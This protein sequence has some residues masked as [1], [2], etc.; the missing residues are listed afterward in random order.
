MIDG[1]SLAVLGLLSLLWG[2]NTQEWEPLPAIAWEQAKVF[3]VPTQ[4]DPVVTEIFQDYLNILAAKGYDPNRQGIWIQSEW[5][6]LVQNQETVPVSAASL[7]KIATSLAALDKWDINHRFETRLYALGAVT[8]GVLQGDLLIEGGGDPLFVWEEAIAVGNAL[9]QLGIREVTGNLVITGNFAMNYKDDPQI[10]GALLKQALNSKDWSGLIKKAY[11]DLPPDTPRPEVVIKGDIQTQGTVP[12]DTPVLLRHQSLTLGQLIKQINIYSN[13]AMSEILAEE[14]GGANVVMER[15]ATLAKIPPGEIQLING[16]GLSVEN[17]I[18]P[19][20]VTLMYMALQEKLKP[21]SMTLADLFP[22][23]GRD[24]KG[25]LEWRSMPKGLTVKTGT[26]NQVSALA[27]IIPTQER[28]VVWFTIINGGSNFDRLRAEQDKVLQRLA[29]H[30]TI[31]PTD[32]TPGPNDEIFL[33]DP[34][35]NSAGS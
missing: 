5:A 33:G 2:G 32:L 16:S 29:K 11:E 12:T 24:R 13:N 27:G 18:S 3:D 19:R 25:T 34:S 14:I 31:L 26:L 23:M 20:A 28:G 1:M 21:T 6:Y 15:V 4:T 10:A 7:T 30:W 22:V 8:D 17:R 9:N 35:R